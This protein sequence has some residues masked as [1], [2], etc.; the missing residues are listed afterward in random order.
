MNTFKI[1]AVCQ[2]QYLIEKNG[3]Y[4]CSVHNYD[5]RKDRSLNGWRLFNKNTQ[6]RSEC[7]NS[8]IHNHDALFERAQAFVGEV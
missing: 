4:F 1:Y 2:G 6:K 3:K 8:I 5:L 7:V